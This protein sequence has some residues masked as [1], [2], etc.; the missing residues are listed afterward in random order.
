M[1]PLQRDKQAAL[2]QLAPYI[3]RAYNHRIENPGRLRSRIIF[4]YELLYLERGWLK[5]RIGARYHHLTAGEILLIKPGVEHEFLETSAECW[6]PHLHFDP[7]YQP[8]SAQVPINF[9]PLE[10]CNEEER[11]W[12][13]ED[14]LGTQLGLPD[15]IRIPNH[16]EIA[17][18]L[19][20]LIHLYERQEIMSL[21]KQKALAL[22]LIHLLLKGLDDDHGPVRQQHRQSLRAVADLII[23]RFNETLPMKELART[24]MLS[25]YHFTRLF[26]VSYGVTPHQFQL[27]QRIERAKE[28][29]RYSSLPLSEIA[30]HVGYSSIHAFSKAF[31]QHEAIPP[32]K[33]MR[34][35][36]NKKS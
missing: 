16:A 3:R 25:E 13:R 7:V 10:E 29:M 30:E 33:Y 18:T 5:V 32:G 20:H 34:T 35:H 24:A 36:L 28:L 9:K 17:V 22:Q 26:K 15:I 21:L 11:S 31:K 1:N 27:R 14:I 6:M 2:L 19:H 23:A 4:D 8:D 12:I